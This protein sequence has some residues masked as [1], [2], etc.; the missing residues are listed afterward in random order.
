MAKMPWTAVIPQI[1]GCE[2]VKPKP[3]EKHW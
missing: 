2:V 1:N 3:A